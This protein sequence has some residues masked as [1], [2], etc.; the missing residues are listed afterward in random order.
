MFLNS[1]TRAAVLAE[2]FSNDSAA[3]GWQVFGNTNLFSFNAGSQALDVTWD[4]SQP[5]SY[6]FH[7]LGT[8][9]GR[10]DDFSM[11]FDLR[12]ADIT[13][14]INT[15]KP[16]P[17]EVA[18]SFL[19]ISQAT[20][21]NFLRGTG[22][23]SP[24]ELEFAY[25][26]DTGFGATISP[27]IISTNGSFNYSG[28]S[29]YTLLALTTGDT[30][31]IVMSYTAS[32][33]T[34]TT[35]MTRNGSAFGPINPVTLSTNFTDFRVDAFAISSY[36]D[37]GDDF[38]SLLAHGSVDNVTITIPP[39]P[40]TNLSGHFV[41]PDLWEARFTS[42]TNWV[43]TLERTTD[44]QIWTTASATTNG[45][46]EDLSLQDTQAKQNNGFYRVRAER[47]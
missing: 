24:N 8:I 36:S 15:N 4:S 20:A 3:R 45:T 44:F 9:L 27:T 46:G 19:N 21:T 5:N 30:F 1:Q 38:D 28:S 41:S 31:H 34:V 26:A 40:V 14:G 23:D 6:F 29:D 18:I 22:T 7:R 47:P 16:G 39:L 12:L 37:T 32:N 35:T 25:F 11:A 33:S 13:P 2:D 10:A 17:F 42:R 43:Y